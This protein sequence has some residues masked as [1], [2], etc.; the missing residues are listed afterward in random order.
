MERGNCGPEVH[1][2][3]DASFGLLAHA[4]RRSVLYALREDGPKTRD[5]LA[6]ELV[7]TGVA[8]DRDRTV[9]S[10]FHTH[11]PKLDDAGVVEYDRDDGVVSLAPDVERLEPYLDIAAHHEADGYEWISNGENW[12]AGI[13]REVQ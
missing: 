3:L 6:D 13:G 7:A 9:A 2:R 4:H 8:D 12:S 1:D 10:L 11:L 5:E